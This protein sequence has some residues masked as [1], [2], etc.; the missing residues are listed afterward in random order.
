MKRRYILVILACG[1]ALVVAGLL[2]FRQSESP[3]LYE[4]TLLPS[5][6]GFRTVPHSINDRGQVV[7]V[8]ETPKRT[9]HIFLWDKAGGFRNLGPFDDPPHVGRLHINN[10]GII[11]GTIA[12][13][14]GRR[15]A[16]LW[17]PNEDKQLLGT[18]GGSNSTVTAFNNKNQLAGYSETAAGIRHAFLWDPNAGM[19]DLGTLGGAESSALDLNDAGQVVGLAETA[20]H[21]FRIVLWDPNGAVTDLGPAGVGPFRACINSRGLVVRR[22]GTTSGGTYFSTWTRAGGSQDLDFVG[23]GS[24]QPCG[25]NDA[26][27]FLVRGDPAHLKLF[28]RIVRRRQEC[29]L[30]DPNDGAIS[31]QEHLPIRDLLYLRVTDIDNN[32]RIIA[33]LREKEP[34]PVRAILL[35][36]VGHRWAK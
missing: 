4:L 31:L 17:D 34:D 12:D 24:A 19:R 27:Q 8:A 18:L 35:E 33:M 21:Q 30:W 13:P 14:N 36:P 5:L 1:A 16:F 29:Y 3:V 10:A 22:L 28:G 26:G 6:G 2:A 32:G 15:K 9:S 23:V 7:G 20:K 11:A 25:L